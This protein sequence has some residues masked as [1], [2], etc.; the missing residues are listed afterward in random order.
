MMSSIVVAMLVTHHRIPG[1]IHN[2]ESMAKTL[3]AV[4]KTAISSPDE[5][6]EAMLQDSEKRLICKSALLSIF[7]SSLAN[8]NP[9]FPHSAYLTSP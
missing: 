3:S 1:F 5:D 4:A 2:F 7:H 8:T 9:I 6:W